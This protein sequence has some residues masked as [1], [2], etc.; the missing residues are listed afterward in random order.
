MLST[1]FPL[2]LILSVT[3]PVH[4]DTTNECVLYA[5]YFYVYF[6]VEPRYI[7]FVDGSEKE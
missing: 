7:A 5:I 6:T 1:R 2:A 3:T 4:F